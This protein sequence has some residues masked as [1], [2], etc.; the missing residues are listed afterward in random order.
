MTTVVV[1]AIGGVSALAGLLLAWR[2]W[3][4]LVPPAEPPAPA[5]WGVGVLFLAFMV[6]ML[7][8]AEVHQV[9]VGTGFFTYWYGPGYPTDPAATDEA[10]RQLIQRGFLFWSQVLATPLVLGTVAVLLA[11]SKVRPRE[12]GLATHRPVGDLLLAVVAA[13]VVTPTAYGL[14]DL[15]A[16]A[17]PRAPHPLEAAAGHG[18]PRVEWV[19]FGLSAAVCA[20]AMEEL[21]F[22]GLF[23]RWM[24]RHPGGPDVGMVLALALSL[25]TGYFHRDQGDPPAVFLA[26]LGF[27]LV[28]LPA[29]LALPWLLRGRGAE[30]AL[31]ARAVFSGALV[32]ALMHADIWPSPVPLFLLGLVLGW[33]AHRTRGLLAPVVLHGLFNAVG[34]VTLL[35][36]AG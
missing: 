10:G 35:L 34:F 3:P 18:L 4:R 36:T 22:R 32:F 6:Y 2:F 24:L 14:Y 17:V 16:L 28:L 26:P 7:M 9:L 8:P 21:F 13:L 19:L 12:A 15:I 23:Q 1:I 5:P 33:L 31:V 27:V 20:P 25:L 29:Y 11:W 30:A